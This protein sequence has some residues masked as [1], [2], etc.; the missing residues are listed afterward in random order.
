MHIAHPLFVKFASTD[1][2]EQR[3]EAH[4]KS[5]TVNTENNMYVLQTGIIY[6][7][8]IRNQDYKNTIDYLHYFTLTC[9]QVK[10]GATVFFTTVYNYT[11]C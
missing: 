1:H 10:T 5:H 4:N 9:E 11:A 2:A 7:I 3:T 6:N 8:H